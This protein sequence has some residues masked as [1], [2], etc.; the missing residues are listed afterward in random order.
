MKY[1][2]TAVLEVSNFTV[3]LMTDN[4]IFKAVNNVSFRIGHGETVTIIGESG[5]GKSTTAMG[6]LQLL[7]QGL[8]ALSGQVKIKGEDVLSNPK[9]IA[10]FRGRGLAL[11]PQDPMTALNPVATI[12]SQL[13]EAIKVAGRITVKQQ[14]QSKAVELLE[15]VRIP[16]VEEQLKK[17]PHQ[18]SG[19]MLQRVL[20]AIALASEPEL[21][22]ADE[23]TSAL[24]VTVQAGILD[25][26]LE[27][28][29]T[30]GISVLM[31]THDIGVAR[32]VS[33]TIHVMKSG[34]FIESGPAAQ[35]VDAPAEEYTRALLSAVPRL[36]E[37]DETSMVAKGAS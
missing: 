35:I 34:K 19:G 14:M 1:Q 20:I 3:E 4:G 36:G 13:R 15:Q 5:S 10:K 32:L 23:P 9:A 18:L 26:L 29:Q 21:L 22:V 8:A 24:D 16:R 6:L 28:Q 37:W 31:I 25:L 17:F 11:I 33:D 27:L 12:G 7:P 30:R 2:D